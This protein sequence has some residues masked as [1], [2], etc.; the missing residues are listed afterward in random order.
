MNKNSI[1]Y[2]AVCLAESEFYSKKTNIFKIP[3]DDTFIYKDDD[4][5]WRISKSN[6]LFD[7]YESLIV[8]YPQY[9]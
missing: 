6:E 9:A 4:G 7:D 8:K 1:A 2:E 3:D 5:Y